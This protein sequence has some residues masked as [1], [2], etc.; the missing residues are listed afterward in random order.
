MLETYFSTGAESDDE[1]VGDPLVRAA[2]GHQLEHFAL[3]RS[4]LC[5]RIVGPLP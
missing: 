3:A 1:P 5:E 2:A 4:Q